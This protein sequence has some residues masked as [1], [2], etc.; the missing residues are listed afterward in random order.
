M[1]PLKR[2][3]EAWVWPGL[4]P[5]CFGRRSFDLYCSFLQVGMLP[6]SLAVLGFCV[7]CVRNTTLWHSEESH[8]CHF[9]AT[10]TI[11]FT[12]G[13]DKG[14]QAGH[15][16][17]GWLP[18]NWICKRGFC[19]EA[20]FC[21]LSLCYSPVESLLI[22]LSGTLS[23]HCKGFSSV[24]SCCPTGAAEETLHYSKEAVSAEAPTAKPLRTETYHCAHCSHLLSL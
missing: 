10:F 18:G 3:L 22:T 1:G 21:L 24:T 13:R 20:D 12:I 4:S 8:H 16:L 9:P 2:P 11:T 6:S 19:M 7:V 14:Q 23:P 17:H 15:C 5:H